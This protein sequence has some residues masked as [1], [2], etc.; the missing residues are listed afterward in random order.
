MKRIFE[1]LVIAGLA[2][3]AAACSG[4]GDEQGSENGDADGELSEASGLSLGASCTDNEECA[5]KLCYP[6]TAGSFCT[7]PCTSDDTCAAQSPGACCRRTQSGQN[8][9]MLASRC[10]AG[11]SDGDVGSPPS[12]D[13]DSEIPSE[14]DGSGISCEPNTFICE[15]KTVM[16]CNLEGD[17]WEAVQECGPDENCQKGHCIRIQGDYD[18]PVDGDEDA[19]CGTVW[20]TS[21]GRRAEERFN[22][23]ASNPSELAHIVEDS[24]N[25]DFIDPPKPDGSPVHSYVRLDATDIEDSDG[26]PQELVFDVYIERTYTYNI[27]MT[28]AGG[29]NWGKVGLFLGER[30]I[31][32]PETYE[33]KDEYDLYCEPPKDYEEAL[34]EKVAYDA[35]CIQSGSYQLKVRVV[36]RNVQSD[37]YS[38]GVDYIRFVPTPQGN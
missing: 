16:R 34:M 9:C 19:V 20:P 12:S 11:G 2:L 26:N 14:S 18:E 17:G 38:I 32:L 1:V 8:I 7:M 22:K 23:E 5:Y 33:F 36:G 6:D 24:R 31:L 29:D 15:D 27:M 30:E 4:D 3:A 35:V 37:G 25:P 28:Y 21:Y 13:G 10:G